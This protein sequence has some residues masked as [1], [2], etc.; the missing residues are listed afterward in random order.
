MNRETW[1]QEEKI[2]SNTRDRKD[3]LKIL[4]L[5]SNPFMVDPRVYKEAK[6]LIGA[7]NEITVLVWDRHRDYEPES[8]VEGIRVVRIHNKGLLRIM[9]NDL[10]RNPLWW[11]KA[12]KKGLELYNTAQFKFD[13]THCH[14]LDTL[15]AGVWLK[16]KLGIKLIYDAHEIFGYMIARDMP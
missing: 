5:L 7:G 12:Y 14:D 2:K 13:V 16:K 10:F 15:W 4:M 3:G 1:I 11:R 6:A 8:F 9:P